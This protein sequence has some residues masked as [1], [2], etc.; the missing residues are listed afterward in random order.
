MLEVE[1]HYDV[2]GPRDIKELSSTLVSKYPENFCRN[3]Q[4]DGSDGIDLW[5]YTLTS[6]TRWDKCKPK[7]NVESC[8]NSNCT[9]YRG[10]QS[11]T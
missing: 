4:A 7:P 11:R 3:S 1:A 6:T 5:C 8:L 9:D 10:F 2:N